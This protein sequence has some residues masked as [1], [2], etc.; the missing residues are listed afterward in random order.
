[1]KNGFSLIELMVSIG[2]IGILVSVATVVYPTYIA[3]S[4]ISSTVLLLEAYVKKAESYYVENNTN[5]NGFIGISIATL[6]D[7][8]P[9]T[10][11]NDIV[12]SITANPGSNSLTLT[13]TFT[14]DNT[15]VSSNLAGN[16]LNLIITADTSGMFTISCNAPTISPDYLP[17]M[18]KPDSPIVP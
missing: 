8:T 1:M 14:T 12:N 17:A 10:N 3:R 18:C 9:G 6:G 15:K 7:Y 13:A 11:N 5:N 16:S 4:Q 2:I